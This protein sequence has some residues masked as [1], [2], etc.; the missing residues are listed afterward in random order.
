M[1]PLLFFGILLAVVV[2][3]VVAT[4]LAQRAEQ[5]RTEAWQRFAEQPGMQFLGEPLGWLPRFAAMELF[6]QGRKH[7]LW[8]AVAVDAGDTRILVADF[9]FLTGHGKSTTTH[10]QTIC[11]LE[12]THF[13]A[14]HC[15]LRPELKWFDNWF[16]GQ[17]IDFDEDPAFSAAFM[18]KGADESAIRALFQPAVRQWFLERKG[19]RLVFEANGHQLVFHTGRCCEPTQTPQLMDQALQIL[20]LLGSEPAEP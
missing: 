1:Q 13:Q 18:L 3:I 8:N 5:Q 17:D 11:S 7:R 10:Q 19:E 2:A 4:V 15:W 9:R 20:K 6:R 12:S 16:G 14:P